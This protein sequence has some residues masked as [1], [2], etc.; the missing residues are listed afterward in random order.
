MGAASAAVALEL[1]TGLLRDEDCEWGWGD[2]ALHTWR[3]AQTLWSMYD[4]LPSFQLSDLAVQLAPPAE[5][6]AAVAA[7]AT[8][9]VV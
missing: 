3:T 2:V 5:G 6:R 1:V 7:A 4:H 9:G 8:R